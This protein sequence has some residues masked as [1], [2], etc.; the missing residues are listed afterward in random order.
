[1][2]RYKISLFWM[3]VVFLAF[4]PMLNAQRIKRLP[5]AY[6]APVGFTD[7]EQLEKQMIESGGSTNNTPWIVFSDRSDNPIYD[8]PTTKASISSKLGFKDLLFVL[9]EKG[10][11]I[12]VAVGAK[13]AD[14]KS[15]EK[16]SK[17]GWIQK[18]KVL[19]WPNSLR[20]ENTKVTQ[21]AFLLN[22]LEEMERLIREPDFKSVR[23]YDGPE[24]SKIIGDRGIYNVYFVFKTEGGR[25]LLAVNYELNSARGSTEIIG[26]VDDTRIE[27]W[28]QRLVLECNYDETAYNQRKSDP[29]KL[30]VGFRM[31]NSAINF[32]RNGTKNQEDII[33][34]NDPAGSKFPNNLR[35]RSNSRRANGEVF[36]FPVFSLGQSSIKS[37]VINSI[38]TR[39]KKGEHSGEMKTE[40]M[41]NLE[42]MLKSIEK[43]TDHLNVA[44]LIEGTARMQKFKP[45]I[46]AAIDRISADL[47]EKVSV[48]Y[49]AGIYRDAN[50]SKANQHFKL[51][52]FS[53]EKRSLINFINTEVFSDFTDKDL[54]TNQRWAMQELLSKAGFPLNENNVLIVIGNNADFYH[55]LSRRTAA[56]KSDEKKFL[57]EDEGLQDMYAKVSEFNIHLGFIQMEN[58]KGNVYSRFVQDA[59]SMIVEVSKEQYNAYVENTRKYFPNAKLPEP[60]M[61]AINESDLLTLENGVRTGAILKP[62]PQTELDDKLLFNF[63][64]NFAYEANRIVNG[65]YDEFRATIKE[66][67]A[68]EPEN[69][70]EEFAPGIFALLSDF[71][72][73]NKVAPS[74]VDQFTKEKIR[75]YTG[76]FLPT[77]I[78]KTSINL[79]KKVVFMP[80][81][82][83]EEYQA[84]LKDLVSKVD[85]PGDVRRKALYDTFIDL[86]QKLTGDKLSLKE[87]DNYDLDKLRMQLAGIAVEGFDL[88]DKAG[89]RVF[90][91]QKKDKFPDAKLEEWSKRLNK[92][93][94]EIRSIYRQGKD[95]PFSYS[96]GDSIYFWIDADLLF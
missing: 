79:Y 32:S 26:W 56:Q 19:L 69:L 47:P 24:S 86:L 30:V 14:N 27:K 3:M 16:V 53:P 76:V 52:K 77:S 31:P 1:M 45:A 71:T 58:Q 43:S 50:L 21:K 13:S 59:R 89:I 91:I 88:E 48:R 92:K 28:N 42:L 12:E 73:K 74:T 61:P 68:F 72:T 46:L 36:R 67:K 87:M 41:L 25:S 90:D 10:A 20:D 65:I 33:W 63:S 49:A 94:E 62:A 57:I 51:F 37:G 39:D 11:W 54:F 17:R 78:G 7:R 23:I 66:G 95:Y 15:M 93:Y 8:K 82:E 64:T 60:S 81:S 75:L 18:N 96:I 29:L 5:D 6:L 22:K 9:D 55:D 44:F 2:S 80:Y 4:Q 83:L 40:D 70:P 85:R 84:V 35:D 34:D 38:P